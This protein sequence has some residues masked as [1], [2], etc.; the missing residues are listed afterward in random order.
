MWMQQW[1]YLDANKMQKKKTQTNKQVCPE[2][3]SE[4]T[5]PLS[6]DTRLR[7]GNVSIRSLEMFLE[8][9]TDDVLAGQPVKTDVLSFIQKAPYLHCHVV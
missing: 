1:V 9:L 5:E 3:H 8:F 4:Q 6:C 2:K 7:T